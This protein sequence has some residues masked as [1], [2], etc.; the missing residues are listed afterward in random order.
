MRLCF[1]FIFLMQAAQLAQAAQARVTV[2][3]YRL[4]KGAVQLVIASDAPLGRYEVQRLQ[5]PE[6]LVLDLQDTRLA[7]PLPQPGSNDPLAHRLRAGVRNG[8]D[9]RLVLDLKDLGSLNSRFKAPGGNNKNQLILELDVPAAA[10]SK[11]SESGFWGDFLSRQEPARDQENE[12]AFRSDFLSRQEPGVG[13]SK[14]TQTSAPKSGRNRNIIVAI[15]A[16]HGGKDPGAL[17]ASGTHE[18]DITL[19]VARRLAQAINKERGMQ[20]VLVRDADIFI[21]LRDR[22]AIARKHKADLFV[23]IHADAFKNPKVQGSSVFTLSRSGASSEAARW[24]A[25][26]E[27]SADLKGGLT[28]DDKDEMLAS[29]LLDLSQSAT[30]HAGTE[31][32]E[33]VLNQLGDLG[34]L[35]IGQVQQAGFAVLKSPDIP[36][37]L[38]ETAFISNPEEERKLKDA[39]HQ[40]KLAAAIAKGVRNYFHASPPAGTLLAERQNKGKKASGSNNSLTEI[41]GR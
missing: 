40:T 2:L 41:A 21:S 14:P 35:H 30:I 7:A 38:V 13:Q 8:Q 20:A 1:L 11:V 36:S 4:V 33:Q 39:R 5:N 29:V 18:K 37:I 16:G 34:N 15:D 9:L 17:G 12:P 31:V 6:R 27:N 28:L 22:M 10:K 19:A 32:A 26:K 23:S 3:D 25:D 24:L